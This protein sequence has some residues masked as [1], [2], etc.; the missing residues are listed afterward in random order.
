MRSSTL[1]DANVDIFAVDAIYVRA[2]ASP[3]R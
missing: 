2:N 3:H 1:L